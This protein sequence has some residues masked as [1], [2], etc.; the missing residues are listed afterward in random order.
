[1]RDEPPRKGGSPV[2]AE[3]PHTTRQPVL[4]PS[5]SHLPRSSY[6][7]R[8][9]PVKLSAA[10]S[11][12]NMVALFVRLGLIRDPVTRRIERIRGCETAPDEACRETVAGVAGLQ[13][14]RSG[15]PRALPL[16]IFRHQS[17]E[18]VTGQVV[19]YS[20]PRQVP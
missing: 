8:G 15:A 3:E 16:L 14:T 1:M 18:Y 10:L 11:R 6:P 12:R 20:P 7:R 2:E 4:A 19:G 13:Q 9:L 17:I 5:R